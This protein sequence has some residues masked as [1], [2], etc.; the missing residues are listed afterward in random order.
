[1]DFELLEKILNLFSKN[2]SSGKPLE[3]NINEDLLKI[4]PLQRKVLINLLCDQPIS[5][6]CSLSN[7]Q[8]ILS[9]QNTVIMKR[10]FLI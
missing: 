2:Q 6:F 1:M 9:F 3:I 10:F 7:D 5:T 8:N 4:L